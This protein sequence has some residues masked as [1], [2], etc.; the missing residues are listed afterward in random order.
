MT[1]TMAGVWWSG[2]LTIA[3]KYEYKSKIII[4]IQAKQSS[5]TQNNQLVVKI[6]QN[7]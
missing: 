5:K 2:L 7:T 3:L 6:L 1:D 4:T